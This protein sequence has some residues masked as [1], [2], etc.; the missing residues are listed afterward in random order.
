[1]A[2]SLHC[3]RPSSFALSTSRALGVPVRPAKAFTQ[4]ASCAGARGSARG[5]GLR[6]EHRPAL[7]S[8]TMRGGATQKRERDG[9][10]YRP[11]IGRGLRARERP[12]EP[13]S[14]RVRRRLGAGRPAAGDRERSHPFFRGGPR[15]PLRSPAGRAKEH[16]APASRRPG[17]ARR[18]PGAGARAGL[19]RAGASSVR[20]AP[21]RGGPPIRADARSRTPSRPGKGPNRRPS[22]PGWAG[23]DR[24]RPC[25]AD[26]RAGW[27]P[28]CLLRDECGP[29]RRPSKGGSAMGAG[30][31]SRP[32]TT[33]RPPGREKRCGRTRVAGRTTP[34]SLS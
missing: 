6:E 31:A 32:L 15:R 16:R 23:L 30:S 4:R 14:A 33:Q 7:R 26:Q 29:E 18:R 19:S 24:R 3:A 9:W 10:R 8:S 34:G 5:H 11:A 21:A 12:A 20:C 2:A 22:S 1:M 25:A 28:K 17:R 27:G 13:R